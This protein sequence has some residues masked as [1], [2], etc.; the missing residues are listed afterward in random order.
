M[1][2]VSHKARDNTHTAFRSLPVASK[3]DDLG[4]ELKPV[5]GTIDVLVIDHVD[6]QPTAN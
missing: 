4:L 5:Q 2:E 1:L 3:E 6:R